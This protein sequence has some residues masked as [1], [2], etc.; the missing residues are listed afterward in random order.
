MEYQSLI[1]CTYTGINIYG[2]DKMV[3][4]NIRKRGLKERV[5]IPYLG[6]RC[7]CKLFTRLT[8]GM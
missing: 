8:L 2:K 6:H 4:K 3:E 5:N 7:H 1:Y